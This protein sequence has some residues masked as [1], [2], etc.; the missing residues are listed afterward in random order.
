MTILRMSLRTLM[1]VVLVMAVDLA[2][3]RAFWGSKH[4]VLTGIAFTGL[5]LNA[6][7]FCLILRGGG[8]GPSGRAC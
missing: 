1:V 3:I 2:V 8:G 5:A 6:G 4:R 7:L